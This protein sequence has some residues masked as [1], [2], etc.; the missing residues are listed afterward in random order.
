VKPLLSGSVKPFSASAAERKPAAVIEPFWAARPVRVPAA[1]RKPAAV[2]EPFWAAR[3]VRV[4][5]AGQKPPS[6]AKTSLSSFRRLVC[7]LFAHPGSAA[8]VKRVIIA[9]LKSAKSVFA[10]SGTPH[11]VRE[12]SAQAGLEASSAVGAESSSA[13][14]GRE[15]RNRRAEQLLDRYGNIILRY[16]YTFVHNTA[17]S[18]EILQETLIRFLRNMPVFE[19]ADHE[20]AWLLRTAGNLA[21]NRIAYNKI[22]RADELNEELVSEQKEDLSF[23]WEAVSQL[24]V[25]Q[26]TAIHLFYQEGCD[27][28]EIAE[29]TGRRESTVRSDLRRGRIRLK[30]ILKEKYDFG[31]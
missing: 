22:R 14:S 18:E 1:E 7:S 13:E 16:A 11:G 5:A 26:R 23:V 3:P 19:S 15:E 10:A 2:I 21:K 6:I 24:P 30:D 4:P 31:G 27:T 12:E 20:K 28:A 17:D 8:S 29:I 9:S 25:N